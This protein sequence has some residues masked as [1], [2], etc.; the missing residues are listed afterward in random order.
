MAVVET[1]TIRV[2]RG[3]Q[4]RL[5]KEAELA[6]TSVIDAVDAAVDLLEEQRL[7]EGRGALLEEARQGD[8]GRDAVVA[9]HARPSASRR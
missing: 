4:R 8:A 1:T 3:T 2:R 7:L 9:R 6:G 5:A